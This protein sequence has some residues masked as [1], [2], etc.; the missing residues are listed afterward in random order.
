MSYPLI[1]KLGLEVT[2]DAGRFGAFVSADDLEKILRESPVVYGKVTDGQLTRFSDIKDCLDT[3][4]AR[5]L[6]VEEIK[7]EP[8]KHEAAVYRNTWND[9]GPRHIHDAENLKCAH[10]GVKLKAEW[11]EVE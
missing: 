8:C 3:H 11:K 2:V 6:L 5:L 4:T 7:K 1:E 9:T 10:C